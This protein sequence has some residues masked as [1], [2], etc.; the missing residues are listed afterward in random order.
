MQ[1][2]LFDQAAE[3]DW[4]A[5]PYERYRSIGRRLAQEYGIAADEAYD[6]ALTCG[7]EAAARRVLRQRWWLAEGAD[8]A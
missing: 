8:A 6:L 2:R 3:I 7:S 5:D 4:E 1:Q